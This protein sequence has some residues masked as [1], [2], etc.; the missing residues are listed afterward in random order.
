MP[1]ALGEISDEGDRVASMFSASKRIVV[2]VFD[3]SYA[4]GSGDLVELWETIGLLR[5]RIPER[6]HRDG[7]NVNLVVQVHSDRVREEWNMPHKP[8]T[9]R[10]TNLDPLRFQ[11]FDFHP[12]QSLVSSPRIEAF[13]AD[14]SQLEGMQASVSKLAAR[15]APDI[16]EE[17]ILAASYCQEMRFFGCNQHNMQIVSGAVSRSQDL[18]SWL[19]TSATPSSQL[20][21][22]LKSCRYNC[23]GAFEIYFK[24]DPALSVVE[25]KASIHEL[26][27]QLQPSYTAAFDRAWLADTLVIRRGLRIWCE[28]ERKLQGLIKFDSSLSTIATITEGGRVVYERKCPN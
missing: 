11:K 27:E 7:L 21:K 28:P 6:G 19:L 18:P 17:K 1:P 22:A 3:S 5:G 23:L 13:L 16:L 2:H 8:L 26:F 20:E 15:T 4:R 10:L 12:A 9:E 25:A 24:P 14:L